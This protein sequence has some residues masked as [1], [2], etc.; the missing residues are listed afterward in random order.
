MGETVGFGES[1]A[2][3]VGARLVAGSHQ[4]LEEAFRRWSSLVHAL[5][6]R[7][8]GSSAAA[9][10]VTQQVF[11]RAWQGRARYDPEHRP[12]PAWLVGIARH[13]LADHHAATARERRLVERA[14]PV[15]APA[16]DDRLLDALALDEA[17]GRLGR[18]RQDVVRL[19]FVEGLTHA[20]V[21]A[22][23]HLPLGTVKSHV[24]RGLLQLRDLVGGDDGAS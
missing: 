19:A 3:D 12:L 5:A 17:L 6:Y 13:V 9:D 15:R 20:E 16:P 8:T 22:R 18:P 23:L 24:R 21:A 14:A 10:D 4:A 11:V 2:D 7:S 1:G